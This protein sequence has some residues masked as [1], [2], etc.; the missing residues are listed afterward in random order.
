MENTYLE[1]GFKN[2]KEYLASVA[3][4]FGVPK[5]KVFFIA[6][7]LGES[8]DFDGLITSVEDLADGME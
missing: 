4:D 7:V 1:L 2:R 8:E 3:E 5:S 6:S